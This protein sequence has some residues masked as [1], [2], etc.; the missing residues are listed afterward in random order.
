MNPDTD[1]VVG[2]IQ[3]VIDE[4]NLKAKINFIAY[5]NYWGNDIGIDIA[6]IN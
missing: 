6:K 2:T 5:P 1:Q 3:L 4:I